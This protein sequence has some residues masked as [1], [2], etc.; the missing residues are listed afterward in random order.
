MQTPIV[1]PSNVQVR[2]TATVGNTYTILRAPAV[3]GPYST[4]GTATV[5]PNG[6]G[7]FTDNSPLPAGAFY[8]VQYP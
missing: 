5:Q 8:R 4:N 7:T 3:T 2:F 6:T 1:S